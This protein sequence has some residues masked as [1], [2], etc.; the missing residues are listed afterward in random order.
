M[1]PMKRIGPPPLPLHLK[2]IS[3]CMV[4]PKL[5]A[6]IIAILLC[7]QYLSLEPYGYIA[8]VCVFSFLALKRC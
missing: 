4:H 6:T 2:S 5:L 8:V 3:P 1:E 7:S